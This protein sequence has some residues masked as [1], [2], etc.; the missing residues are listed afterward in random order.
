MT[1]YLL[2][3]APLAG[4]LFARQGAIH[5]IQPWMIR[6][7]AVTSIL[8]YGETHEFIM[9]R[10]NSDRLIQSLRD[11][12]DHIT[13]Y[14]LTPAIAERYA[15]IRRDLRP[16]YGPGLIGDIDTLI[17]ATALELNLIVVTT[18]SDFRRVPDLKYIL[19]ERR[20]FRLIEQS[21]L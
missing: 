1:R 4:T 11:L 15:A 6:R 17:A 8:V 2:D 20:T 19:L 7:E 13:P 12:T 18:D 9:G 21:E 14:N 5:L 10:S 3:V 16:P